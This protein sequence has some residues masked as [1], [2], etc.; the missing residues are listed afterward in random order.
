MN[1]INHSPSDVTQD[2]SYYKISAL[3]LYKDF[4]NSTELICLNE[5]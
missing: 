1:N 2:Q 4:V 5:I 3:P